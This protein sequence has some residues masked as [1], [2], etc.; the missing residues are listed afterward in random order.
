MVSHPA[1]PLLGSGA[2]H[3]H[4]LWGDPAGL[5]ICWMRVV[6]VGSLAVVA[7]AVKWLGVRTFNF[8]FCR[9]CSEWEASCF[10]LCLGLRTEEQLQMIGR[11]KKP[12]QKEGMTCTSN[13]QSLL[14]VTRKTTELTVYQLFADRTIIFYLR[15]GES[16]GVYLHFT[17]NLIASAFMR[18]T[19]TTNR[20]T[21]SR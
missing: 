13:W 10:P 17:S 2:L 21:P 4:V 11:I 12:E 20:P 5:G 18:I 3:G 14:G 1:P 19:S 7:S 8:P 6:A 16:G 9:Q 15:C